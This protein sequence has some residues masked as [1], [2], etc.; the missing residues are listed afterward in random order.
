M[1]VVICWFVLTAVLAV[2]AIAKYLD[3]PGTRRAARDLRLPRPFEK[4]WWALCLPTIEALLA[5]GLTLTGLG[6]AAGMLGRAAAWAT[7]AL[8]L[9]YTVLIAR[10]LRFDDPVDCGCFGKLAPMQVTVRTLVR[11]LLL[12]GFALVF[13]LVSTLG[14]GLW[15]YLSEHGWSALWGLIA[16]C[17]AGVLASLILSPGRAAAPSSGLSPAEDDYLRTP[18][19]MGL[20]TTSAGENVTLRQLASTRAVVLVMVTPWC[21][22]CHDVLPLV[23]EWTRSLSSIL[24]VKVMVFGTSDDDGIQKIRDHGIEDA[25]ILFDHN[26]SVSLVMDYPGAPS[27]VLLGADGL[28]AGGPVSG[29]DQI[30]QFVRDIHTEVTEHLSESTSAPGI[31]G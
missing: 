1:F 20:A 16:L 19:P 18:I 5:I 30:I 29:P 31:P 10:A 22:Y 2:S 24:D 25:N 6:G 27:A 28:L 9:V 8:M 13:S 7:V 15:S 3:V 21:R 23:P 12:L 26:D 14:G 17:A 11:N 4:T